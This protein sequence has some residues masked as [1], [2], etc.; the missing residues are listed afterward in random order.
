MLRKY[1][2]PYMA[3]WFAISFRWIMLVGLVVS[4]SLGGKL[5]LSISWPLGLLIAWNLTM[6]TFAGLNVRMSYHRPIS[7]FI[8]L[9]LAGAFYWMQGGLHGPAVWTG[10]LPV[11]TGSIYFEFLGALL[12]SLLFSGLMV[13]TGMQVEG[14]LPLAIAISVILVLL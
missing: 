4:L 10:L 7:T 1:D 5:E 14:D 3:D 9:V 11:L 8:D 6:T 2:T 13:Y 12:A